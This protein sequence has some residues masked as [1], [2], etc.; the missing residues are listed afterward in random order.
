MWR[1][2]KEVCPKL[3]WSQSDI[4]VILAKLY[5]L[6]GSDWPRVLTDKEQED[7]KTRMGRRLRNM[8]KDIR[9]TMHK[10]P[11]TAWV[12]ELFHDA[13]ADADAEA[14]EAPASRTSQK[15]R[16]AASS[17]QP[18]ASS[19]PPVAQPV[20]QPA[21]VQKRPAAE[22]RSPRPSQKKVKVGEAFFYGWCFKKKQ[23]WRAPENDEDA[24][25]YTK[26]LREP[27]ASNED[28]PIQALFADDTVWRNIPEMTCGELQL[29][30]LTHIKK[31][32]DLWRRETADGIEIRVVKKADRNAWGLMAIQVMRADGRWGMMN[33]VKVEA[34]GIDS[35][36]KSLVAAY[37][38]TVNLAHD[39]VLGMFSWAERYTARDSRQE[40]WMKQKTLA[41]LVGCNAFVV[42]G[43][44][45]L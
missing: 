28:T 17:S 41:R 24:K 39:Y 12:V 44:T 36:E 29:L 43:L 5:I 31:G 25:V 7:W 38:F 33:M 30:K 11:T 27:A 45:V 26:M 40:I 20:A 8:S 18:A 21:A 13:P 2:V 23:A 16:R 42:V 22:P 6:K 37:D 1:R 15:P 4:Q 19:S 3:S 34:F 10:H 35:E 14:A 32:G 9:N